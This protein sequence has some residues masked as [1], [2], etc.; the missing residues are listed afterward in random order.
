MLATG[1]SRDVGAR[2]DNV[3]VYAYLLRDKKKKNDG[4]TQHYV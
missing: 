4:A 2:S 3:Q 1:V